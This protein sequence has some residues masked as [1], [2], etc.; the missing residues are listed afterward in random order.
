M[1]CKGTVGATDTAQVKGSSPPP[2]PPIHPPY[3]QSAR[4]RELIDKYNRTELAWDAKLKRKRKLHD[5]QA[6]ETGK[7]LA[8]D[9]AAPDE[10]APQLDK[11]QSSQQVELLYTENGFP[12]YEGCGDTTEF[13]LSLVQ[14]YVITRVIT[15]E[16][17]SSTLAMKGETLSSEGEMT[18]HDGCKVA[19]INPYASPAIKAV[20]DNICKREN[21]E[22]PGSRRSLKKAFSN[23]A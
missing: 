2:H 15:T 4:S 13:L 14:E 3:N 12:A 17:Q 20:W 22:T 10:S 5:T 6:T 9:I 11:E 19:S 8:T 1:G 16:N 23:D 21:V 18:E 7:E